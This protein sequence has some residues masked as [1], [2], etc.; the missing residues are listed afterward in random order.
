MIGRFFPLYARLSRKTRRRL[1]MLLSWVVVY[2]VCAAPAQAATS[3]D[4]IGGLFTIP[5]LDKGQKPL[6]FEAYSPQRYQ[7]YNDLGFSDVIEKVGL[8]LYEALMELSYAIVKLAIGLTW[9]LTELTGSSVGTD[10]I[11]QGVGSV[12]RAVEVW[13]LPTAIAIGALIAYIRA[14]QGTSDVLGQVLTVILAAGAV[15]GMG[16][17]APDIIHGLDGTRVVLG[18]TVNDLGAGAITRLDQPFKF[19]AEP[20]ITSNTPYA[21]QRKSGDVVWREFFV[22]PWCQTNFGSQAA[23]RAYADKWLAQPNYKAR[24]NYLNNVIAR[25][26]GGSDSDTVKYIKGKT[27]GTRIG[28]S[29]FTLVLSLGGAIVIGGLAFFALLPWLLALVMMF[30]AVFFLCLIVVPGRPRQIGVDYIESILGLTLLSALSGGLLSAMLLVLIQASKLAGTKGWLPSMLFSF[31]ALGGTWEARKQLNRR[32]A[33]GSGG[34]GAGG[35]LAGLAVAKMASRGV[36]GAL[37]SA[38]QGGRRGGTSSA[39]SLG[40]SGAGPGGGPGNGGPSAG[41]RAGTAARGAGQAAGMARHPIAAGGRGVN[42]AQQFFSA[43]GH[44]A[45]SSVA[46]NVSNLKESAREGYARG[47]TGGTGRA[48]GTTSTTAGGARSM[49][50]GGRPGRTVGTDRATARAGKAPINR[51]GQRGTTSRNTPPRR[52]SHEAPHGG[53]HAGSPY[54]H[55]AGQQVAQRATAS[56]YASRPAGNAG[57]LRGPQ[58]A[59]YRV[60]TR[61]PPPAPRRS[62]PTRVP[63]GAT[64]APQSTA[65]RPAAQNTPA[66]PTPPRGDATPKTRT[67][68]LRRNKGSKR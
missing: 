52:V 20:V 31:A 2:T 46:G 21:V 23:C 13:I 7:I 54:G 18:D 3:P 33:G 63:T 27:P 28:L 5:T 40:Q 45:K 35:L 37:R 47:A 49:A 64:P 6:L 36:G 53:T 62:A 43:G 17:S 8:L 24:Q 55:R 15:V 29:L 60:G 16:A 39:S 51:D 14:R 30:L 12:A 58:P 44:A 65:A 68:P 25:Q 19:T 41:Q 67:R 50:E 61:V 42:R 4:G 57:A 10:S 56:H 22:T 11:A 9:W 1:L 66:R 59:G 38:G 48:A 26:E 34:A 32:L